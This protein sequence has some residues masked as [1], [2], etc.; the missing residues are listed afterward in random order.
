MSNARTTIGFE[1]ANDVQGSLIQA[2]ATN[3]GGFAIRQDFMSVIGD[4]RY[5]NT[6]LWKRLD[7]NKVPAESPN[8]QEL[9]R[10][11]MPTVGF[12]PKGNL[13]TSILNP[14]IPFDYSDIPQEV[15]A[16]V[17][18]IQCEHFAM[19]MTQQQGRPYGNQMNRD[20]EDLI[21]STLRFLE[22]SLYTG[23]ASIDPLQFNGLIKQ[24]PLANHIFE[25]DLTTANPDTIHDKLDEICQR[26]AFRPQSLMLHKPTHIFCSGA[27]LRLI[28]REIK[29]LQL[30]HNVKEI[31]PGVLVPSIMTSYGYVDIV[32]TPYLPDRKEGSVDIISYF[33]VDLS[34]LEWHGVSPYGGTKS[35]EPQIFDLSHVINGLPTLNERMILMYGTLKAKNGGQGIYR[36]DVKAPSGSI[37]VE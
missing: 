37:F 7:N 3:V 11:N 30:F 8:V 26:S 33:V 32:P 29:Q 17:G 6:E 22:R 1:N 35:F 4:Y 23:D 18:R 16:I 19:S 9:R 21:L 20:T 15:K 24:M 25:A 14:T 13:A 27:G 28:T 12:V 2:Q 5:K 31:S 10:S 36:L 34:N